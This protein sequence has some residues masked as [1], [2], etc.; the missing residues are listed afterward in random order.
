MFETKWATDGDN[1][2]PDTNSDNTGE[3]ETAETTVNSL[4]DTGIGRGESSVPFSARLIL[5]MSVIGGAGV[6]ALEVKRRQT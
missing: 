2:L 6:I 1:D 3:L 5:L 4:P